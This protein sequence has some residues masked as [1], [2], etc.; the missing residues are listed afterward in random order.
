MLFLH[1]TGDTLCYSP[2]KVVKATITCCMLHN[3]C[4]RN[5]TP[6]VGSDD[7]IPSVVMDDDSM[8]LQDSATGMDQR[9]KIAETLC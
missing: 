7:L 1:H 2:E 5:G 9:R 6:I 3:I 4:R 8:A